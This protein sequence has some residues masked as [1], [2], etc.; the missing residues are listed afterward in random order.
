MSV[1][2]PV[3]IRSIRTDTRGGSACAPT[4]RPAE[5]F[6]PERVVRLLDDVDDLFAWFTLAWRPAARRGVAV[7]S[8]LAVV[9]IFSL[10]V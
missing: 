1:E 7:A 9:L 4:S 5:G 8:V 2:L 10:P 3:E 6:D